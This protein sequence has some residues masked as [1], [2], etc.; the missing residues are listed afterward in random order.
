MII[1]GTM[2]GFLVGC[3]IILILKIS[4]V[5]MH[6]LREWQYQAQKERDKYV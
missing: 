5:S 4:P 2:L 6:E 3:M 1:L